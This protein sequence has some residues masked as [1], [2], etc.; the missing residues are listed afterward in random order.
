MSYGISYGNYP[1]LQGVKKILVV[2][3][4]HH[5]DVLLTSPLFSCLKRALPEAKIDAFLYSDTLPML[6]GHPAIGGFIL[7]D[8]RKKEGSWARKIAYEVELLREVR[9]GG[10]DLVIN[11][12]EGDRGAI[13]ARVSG[14]PFRVGFDPEGK[15]F[16]G[17]AA[18]YTHLV[19]NCK[20]P[21]HAVERQLDALRRI[22][23]FPAPWERD[24]TFVI[25][26]EVERRVAAMLREGGIEPGKYLL[27]HPASRWRFKCTSAAL[28]AQV[29]EECGWPVVLTG[30]PA[31]Y[32]QQM[33][34]DIEAL[35]V[36]APILNLA[37][38]T[39]LKELGALIAMSRATLC[40]DS[41][42]LHIASALKAPVV[43]LFG[44]TSEKN[45]GPWMHRRGRVVAQDTSCRPCGLDGCG[46]S[47]R[48]DCLMTLS[49]R[50][51]LGALK[52]V[53]G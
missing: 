32:E 44:P 14:A 10:Y 22:G 47:K 45:W 35:A 27:L 23:L 1:D 8:R 51:I 4:R 53:T 43:A 24:L 13:A 31:S 42:A 29:V 46:G 48:S 30:G 20:T 39:S 36:N 34:K 40:V 3:L 17:K 16:V 37:G 18:L 5:G 7:Y 15:G 33:A 11:L 19:K 52:D 41:V 25:P 49:A 21:R 26:E 28:M 2:K 9:R 38:K 6:E 12:T 50:A